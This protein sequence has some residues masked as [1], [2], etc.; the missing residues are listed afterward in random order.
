L[1]NLYHSNGTID[2]NGH[3]LTINGDLILEDGGINVNGGEL[4]IKG[5]YNAYKATT[6][7]DGTITYSAGGYLSMNNINDK[8]TVE[9]DFDTY[10]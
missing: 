1:N 3:T 10:S 7:K 5:N 4:I 2:L 9:G 6:N 8:V